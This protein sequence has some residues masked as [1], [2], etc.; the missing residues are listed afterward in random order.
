MKKVGHIVKI[1]HI[2][3]GVSDLKRSVS[4]YENTMDLKKMSEDPTYV[5][6]D[7]G[8]VELGFGPGKPEL[9]LLV[10]DVDTAYADLR[11]KGAKF[12]GE[13]RDQP[14]G[15]R[16]VT[17]LDPDGNAFVLESFKCRTCGKSYQSYLE[18]AEHVK[19]H[20]RPIKQ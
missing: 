12:V 3:I 13:P 16:S 10:D 7:V 1:P 5:I 2:K 15:A 19:E 14:W 11:A 18:L 9:Y 20:K 17:I 6:F 4:F 8:G